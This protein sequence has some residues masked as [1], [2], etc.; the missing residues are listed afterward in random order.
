MMSGPPNRETPYYIN[1]AKRNQIACNI[2]P[3]RF[4]VIK[5]GV[6]DDPLYKFSG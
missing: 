2:R 6:E 5:R 3:E 1:I 4:R